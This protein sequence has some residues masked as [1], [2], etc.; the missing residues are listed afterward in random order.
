VRTE[1]TIDAA[2]I[3]AFNERLLNREH[4]PAKL[5]DIHGTLNK[6]NDGT[7]TGGVLLNHLEDWKYAHTALL[8]AD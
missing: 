6:P 2:A 8:D 3:A 1:G 7:W 5:E 4:I